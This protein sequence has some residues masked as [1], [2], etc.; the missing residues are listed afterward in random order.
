M[1]WV[2]FSAGSVLD[3]WLSCLQFTGVGWSLRS[4]GEPL[5]FW[6]DHE[7]NPSNLPRREPRPR[8]AGAAATPREPRRYGLPA[9]IPPV[10]HRFNDIKPLQAHPDFDAAKSGDREA[11]ARLVRDLITPEMIAEARKFEP[12]AVY[13]PVIAIE[14]SG[15]IHSACHGGTAGIDYGG[16]CGD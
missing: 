12:D 15:I 2:A 6:Q 5:S 9:S 7:P 11:A 16:H 4:G 1:G 14:A 3:I 8:S 13:V 10:I